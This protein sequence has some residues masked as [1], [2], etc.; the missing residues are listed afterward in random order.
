MSLGTAVIN[1]PTVHRADDIRRVVHWFRR[2][3]VV[4]SLRKIGFN[5]RPV[6]VGFGVDEAA[7]VQVF[8]RVL[9]LYAVS[10]VPQTLLI[11]LQ[12]HH[13]CYIILAVNNVVK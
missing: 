3:V 9:R 12:I 5:P 6:H 4:L 11:H 13:R 2:L 1:G 8:L 10:I 7:L